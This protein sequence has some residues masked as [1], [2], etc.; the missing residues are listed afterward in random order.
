MYQQFDD[1]ERSSA[2]GDVVWDCQS[3]PAGCASDPKFGGAVLVSLL[4]DHGVVIDDVPEAVFGDVGEAARDNCIGVEETNKFVGFSS[5]PLKFIWTIF[6][7]AIGERLAVDIQI[8]SGWYISFGDG[9]RGC[10]GSTV[11]TEVAADAFGRGSTSPAAEVV[12]VDRLWR[13][14][15]GGPQNSTLCGLWDGTLC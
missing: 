3:I 2:G 10:I 9:K 12:F 1:F 14:R 13:D 11:S 8:E 15:V 4:L 6:S 5:F 7:R